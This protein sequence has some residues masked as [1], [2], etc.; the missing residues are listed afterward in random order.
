M[1]GTGGISLSSFC[2]FDANWVSDTLRLR[3]KRDKRE[4]EGLEAGDGL[5][6]EELLAG[7]SGVAWPPT[8]RVCGRTASIEAARLLEDCDHSGGE[9]MRLI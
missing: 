9:S 6:V 1:E 3:F 8:E 2:A 7:K 5:R 4:D